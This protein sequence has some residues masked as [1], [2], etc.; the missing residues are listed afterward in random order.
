[1]KKCGKNCAICPYIDQTRTIKA[2]NSNFT[3]DI[4][5][6]VNCS[7]CN[8]IYCITCLH[9]NMQYIGESGQSLALKFGQHKGYVRNR[10]LEQASRS[11][12]NQKGHCMSDMQVLILRK[13]KFQKRKRKNVYKFIQHCIQRSTQSNVKNQFIFILVP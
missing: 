9:C 13:N 7:S 8:I 3:H 10:K 2:S 6:A 5:T 1:M 4:E 12:F 11:H